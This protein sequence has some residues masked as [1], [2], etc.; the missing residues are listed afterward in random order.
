MTGGKD[1]FRSG[2]AEQQDVCTCQRIWGFTAA[3]GRAV[4]LSVKEFWL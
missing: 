3:S 1:D 2:E 4:V